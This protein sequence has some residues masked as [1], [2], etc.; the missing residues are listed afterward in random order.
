MAEFEPPEDDGD[1]FELTVPAEWEPGVYANASS[2]SFT[3]REFTLDFVRVVPDGSVGV[4]VARVACSSETAI[5]LF[6]NLQSQLRLW[7]DRL[8]SDR[9]DDGNGEAR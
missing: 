1:E 8:L 9:G 4:L 7:S 3:T 5:D 6:L 2:V